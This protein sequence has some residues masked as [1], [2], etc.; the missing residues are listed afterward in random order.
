MTLLISDSNILIDMVDGGLLVAMFRL[1]ET[2]AVPDVL[3]E[4]E[5]SS[6][7]P[8]LPSL[9]LACMTLQGEGVMEAYRL[10]TLCTGRTA[11][12]Q[13]DL[14][15]L[16]LAKQESCPLLTG[17]K[18]LRK[19]ANNEHKKIEIRGTLWLVEQMVLEQIITVV[20]ASTA[21]KEMKDAGSRLP[22]PEVDRQVKR[23]G[24]DYG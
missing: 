23:L 20:E 13:N 15:A 6:Q 1:P 7:H 3:Y 19:L 12:S 11:P 14:F 24:N 17:D 22:W 18:R 8:E 16:L 10:K 9:G 21:Y 2:F 5:L 4:E